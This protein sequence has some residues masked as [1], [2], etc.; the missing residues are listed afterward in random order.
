MPKN[1]KLLKINIICR[2]IVDLTGRN[3]NRVAVMLM[4]ANPDEIQ[5]FHGIINNLERQIQ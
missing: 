2:K 5:E 1:L 4:R 3:C